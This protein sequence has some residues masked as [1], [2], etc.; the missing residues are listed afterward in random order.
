MNVISTKRTLNVVMKNVY[1][2]PMIVILRLVMSILSV[3]M[4]CIAV[5]TIHVRKNV[6]VKVME[7]SVNQIKRNVAM[8]NVYP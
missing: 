2:L 3:I 7:L 6:H 1:P 5:K 4:V 8:E